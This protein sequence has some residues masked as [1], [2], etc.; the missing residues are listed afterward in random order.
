M[1]KLQSYL[2]IAFCTFTIKGVCSS[3]DSVQSKFH[4]GF[5]GG[6]SQNNSLSGDMYGGMIIPLYSFKIETNFGYT[7]F[8]NTTD[9]DN[10]KDLLYYSHGVFCEANYFLTSNFYGGVRVSINMNFVDKISQNK[11]DDVSARNPPTYFTGIAGFG[12]L[13]YNL[14]IGKK[15]NFRLQGQAGIQN[16]HI[17]TGALYFS[18]SNGPFNI[19]DE[20][21][22]EKQSKFLYNF[23][24]GLLVKL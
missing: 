4:F 22:E 9:F 8:N 23:S 21:T 24:V 1:S 16:Y 14:P 10:V 17:A 13:G 19:S 15:I 20:Y 12:Q 7:Y 3:S 11:Y 5:T 6:F 2:L 18:S